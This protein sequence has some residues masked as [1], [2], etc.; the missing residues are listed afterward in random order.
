MRVLV[1]CEYS[2][3]VRDAFTAKG[4]YAVSCDLLPSETPGLHY[5]GDVMSIIT[6]YW[7]MMIAFPPC[8]DLSVPGARWFVDKRADGRQQASIAFFMGIARAEIPRIAIENPV[9]IMS[10]E[11][12]CGEFQRAQYP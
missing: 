8:T 5:Q 9:G 1:A 4:H 7:D 2:G 6:D 11:W 10:T 12:Q 3:A